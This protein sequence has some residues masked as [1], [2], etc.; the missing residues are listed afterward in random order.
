MRRVLLAIAFLIILT[1]LLNAQVKINDHT[2]I[3]FATIEQGRAILGVKDDYTAKLSKFDFAAKMH[4]AKEVSELDYCALAADSVVNWTD[5]EKKN[6]EP[7]LEQVGK[8][9]AFLKWQFPPTVYLVKTNGNEENRMSYTRGNGVVLP[10][11]GNTRGKGLIEHELF[12][13]LSRFNPDMRDQLYAVIGFKRCNE[14]VMPAVIS[15]LTIANPDCPKIQH[16][17]ELTY[18]GKKINAALVWYAQ[19]PY[20]VNAGGGLSRYSITKL[21]VIEQD[22]KDKLFKAVLKDGQPV[23]LN[24]NDVNGFYEQVGRNTAYLI[25][26]EEAMADNFGMLVGGATNVRSPEILEK[27]RAVLSKNE[28]AAADDPK[29]IELPKPRTEGGKP[30]MEALKARQSLRQFSNKKIPL[31]VL[32]NLLWAAD[33]INRPDGRRTAPTANNRQEISIYAAMSD[34]LYLYDAKAN[35]LNQVLAE[36]IRGATGTQPFVAVA[37]LNLV[38]VADFSKLATTTELDRTLYSAADTGFISQNV[39][40][41]CASEGLSTVVRGLVDRAKLSKVM[42]LK[43]N[44]RIILA[45]TVGYPA[46]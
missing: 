7:V 38:Y 5:E 26:P 15:Q 29:V 40:L 18:Q 3:D 39:Y 25:H 23:F 43:D 44:Q 36:D 19:K 37:P 21:M 6:I 14:I 35:T 17:I 13:V 41:F 10:G 30:L 32:S 24:I 11:R 2:V 31:D 33:G 45:Q 4:T 8:D 1:G 28:Q 20:D 46:E 16:Y 12:H 42:N 27:I 9:L 22:P 34:G